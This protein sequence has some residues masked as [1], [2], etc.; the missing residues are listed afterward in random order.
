MPATTVV[1]QV[2]YQ[3]PFRIEEWDEHRRQQEELIRKR[4]A[5]VHPVKRHILDIIEGAGGPIKIVEV[6]NKFAKEAGHHWDNR[7]TKAALR[8]MAFQWIGMCVKEFLIARH[9]RKWVVFLGPDNP[10][11]KA[12]LQRIEDTIKN[13]PKPNI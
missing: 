12:W 8:L 5:L 11:R 1:T 7:A 6:A 3:K 9:K 2:F 10:Q 4:A 13:F